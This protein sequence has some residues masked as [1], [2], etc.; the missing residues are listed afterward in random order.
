MKIFCVECDE[1]VEPTLVSGADVYPRR[2]D[3]AELPFWRCEACKNFVGTHHKTKNPTKPLGVIA[4]PNLKKIRQEIH[5]KLDLLWR[6]G[7]YNR[8]GLYS[9][10]S[11][12]LGREY[13]T[14]D[15]RNLREATEILL[16]VEDFYKDELKLKKLRDTING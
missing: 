5:S 7:P 4:N 6:E 11:R 13:H 3:L 2:P 15:L 1:K 14:A 16:F 12:E 10:L 8:K 9:L